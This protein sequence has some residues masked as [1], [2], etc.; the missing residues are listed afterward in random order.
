MIKKIQLKSVIGEVLF[1]MEQE[2]GTIKDAVEKAIKEMELCILDTR[3]K[4]INLNIF[5]INIKCFLYYLE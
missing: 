3:D 5:I 4:I 1:E 2:N